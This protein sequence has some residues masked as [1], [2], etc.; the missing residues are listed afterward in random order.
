MKTLKKTRLT[1]SFANH[2]TDAYCIIHLLTG[3]VSFMTAFATCLCFFF[4]CTLQCS[5][6]GRIILEGI[7]FILILCISTG[8]NDPQLNFSYLLSD[9]NTFFNDILIKVR[10]GHI[11]TLTGKCTYIVT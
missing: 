2:N 6:S 4:F 8:C 10:L 11:G 9:K 5:S 3:R 7:M 1:Y